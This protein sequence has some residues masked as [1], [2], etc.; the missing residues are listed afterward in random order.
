MTDPVTHASLA[1]NHESTPPPYDGP[2]NI[3]NTNLQAGDNVLAVELH[4]TS[5]TSTDVVLAM[6]VDALIK[7]QTP[8]VRLNIRLLP[9]GGNPFAAVEISWA[10][11]PG[12]VLVESTSVTG[13]W[14][15]VAGNPTSPYVT[16]P[17]GSTKFYQLRNP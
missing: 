9:S 3:G 10:N 11:A 16:T 1:V 2:I 8:Q 5:A 14:T 7:S 13:P 4:Q 12:Y 17:T 6:V 15:P